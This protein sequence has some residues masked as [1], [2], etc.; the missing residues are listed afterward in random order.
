MEF[1][2]TTVLITGA[3]RGIGRALTEEFLRRGVRRVYAGMRAPLPH[4]DPRVV[5][6]ALDVT[7]EEQIRAAAARVD[8][9][10]VL[11]N[12][13]G[14]F[15][16][17][18][19]TGRAALERHLAVNLFGPWAV[20]GAFEPHL[21]AAGGT[22]VT[23]VSLMALAPLPVTPAYSLSK[24]AALSLTQSQRALLAGRGVR[25]HAVL[26]GPTDTDMTR[27]LPIPKATPESVAAAILDAVERGEEEIFPDPMSHRLESGWRDGVAKVLERQNTAA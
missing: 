13:A 10:D 27:D 16:P 18:D 7:D 11:V 6:L 25:V 24:A 2:D 9:L 4:A 23:N 19:L 8:A 21:V 15:E 22:V 20:T 14:V 1:N 12:N 3:G 17:D 5:P 26:T